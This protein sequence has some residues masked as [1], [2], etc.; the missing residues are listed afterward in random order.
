MER[1]KPMNRTTKLVLDIVMGAVIPILILNYLTR[2]L[3]AI[4]AYILSA[5]VPVAWVLLDLFVI[6]RRFNFITTYVGL[7]AIV[8]G[9]LAFW[10]VD[11][12]L[13]ALKDTAGFIL[14]ALIFGGSFL[15]ARPIMR[16]FLIQ[17]L[18]PDTPAKEASL[19]TLLAEAKV[20]RA[21]VYGSLIVLIANVIAGI[22]NFYLNVIIVTAPVGTEDFNL[23]VARVNAITRIA[24]T[25]PDM[26]AFGIAFWMLYRALFAHLPSEEGK[27][28]LESDF[29]ELV[30]LREAQQS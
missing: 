9:V 18:D 3:G 10:L 24:L 22:V 8:R 20:Y 15:V 14:T 30:R 28:Q 13:F 12:V 19:N 6:T 7:S 5:L 11:G 25:I 27:D 29:W 23:Q 17:A 26:L 16:Y 4:N 2:P 21:L 1:A